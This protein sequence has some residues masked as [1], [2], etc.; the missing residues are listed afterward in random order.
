MSLSNFNSHSILHKRS[1]SKGYSFGSSPRNNLNV[2]STISPTAKYHIKG[3][4][5]INLCKN[6]GPSFGVGRES[7]VEKTPL[8][9][10]NNNCN[11]NYI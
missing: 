10:I 7:S 9:Y 6:K 11:V 5:E 8:S 2:L 3:I 4:V 1:K